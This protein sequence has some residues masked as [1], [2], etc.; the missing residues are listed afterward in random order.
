MARSR[1]TAWLRDELILALDLYMREGPTAPRE[2]REEVSN[3]LRAIPIEQHLA[4]DPKFRSEKA[5]SYKLYNFVALDPTRDSKGFPHGGQGD[6]SVWDE[7]VY[8]R[9]SL[10]RAAM[11]IRANLDAITP[12]EAD[13]AEPEVAEAAEGRLLTRVHRV[14]E[15]NAKLVERKKSAAMKKKGALACQ[16]CGFDFS[17][18]YGERGDGFIECHH[19]VPVSSLKPGDSTRLE[20]LALVCANCHRMIHRRS[21][22]LTVGDIAALVTASRGEAIA[23]A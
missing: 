17:V 12:D 14:R 20:D 10:I 19:T 3:H 22:W 2:S 4:A 11:A 7:F 15:R 8:D 9:A 5:V 13:E 18:V 21:P 6:A 1:K 23:D 16:A